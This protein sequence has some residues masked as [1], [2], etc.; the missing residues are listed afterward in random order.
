MKIFSFDLGSASI[1]ECVREDDKIQHLDSLL[2]DKDFASTSSQ[3][4]VRR[5]HRTRLAHKAREAWWEKCAAEAGIEVLRSSPQDQADKRLLREFPASGDETIYTSC[6]LRI[7]LLQGKKLEGWQIYKAVRSAFQH[8]G[9]DKDIAWDG[10]LRII[11]KKEKDGIEL[12]KKEKQRLEDRANEDKAAGEYANKLNEWF[13]DT[14]HHFPCYY[15]A[16]KLGLWTPEKPN[17]FKNS[18]SSH[19]APARNKDTDKKSMLV[20]PRSLV[21]KELQMLLKQASNFFPKLKDKENYI[22]FG[23]GE[24]PYAAITDEKYK[25]HRGKNWEH[26]GLLGQKTPRF[27]NRIV[28]QCYLIPRLNVCKAEDMLNKEV[29][30]LLALK[31][32]RFTYGQSTEAGLE[33]EQLNQIFTDYK[34]RLSGSFKEAVPA[35]SWKKEIKNYGGTVN[36][37]QKS[38]PMPKCSGRSRFCRPVLK[39][40][41]ELILS[42]KNPHDFYTEKTQN[43]ANTDPLK[44]LVKEDYS[45]LLKMPNNW[46]KIY[47]PDT[48][49]ED[50]NASAE[51]RKKR[52]T[53]I[54]NKINNPV[55]KHRLW[56]LTERFKVLAQKH[57]APDS[58]IFEVARDEFTSEEKLRKMEME[59][60]KNRKEIE[61]ALKNV[62]D[63]GLN[64]LKMRLLKQQGGIDI[65]DITENQTLCEADLSDYEVDHIVPRSRGGSDGISNK[66]LTKKRLNAD[67]LNRTP[68]EW[69]HQDETTWAKF[70]ENIKH[71]KKMPAAKKRLL[72]SEHADEMERKKNDLQAT[73]YIEKVA[74]QLA[75]LYF[76]WGLNTQDDERKIFVVTGGKT[77]T[78]RRQYGLDRLLHAGLEKDEFFK[79][80]KQGKIKE[81]N[82]ENKKHHALDALVLSIV[83]DYRYNP[84]TKKDEAPAFFTPTFCSAALDKVFPREIKTLKPAL[85]K[86]ISALRKRV[87]DGKERYFF[88][89]RLD[90]SIEKFFKM[91]EI[92]KPCKK[93]FDLQI[94]KDFMHML[95]Q[96]ITQE[97]WEK[98]LKSY[99]G[100][101]EQTQS[102][103]KIKKLS[104]ITNHCPAE[105]F[106]PEEVFN[107]DKSLKPKVRE[108]GQIGKMKG[109]WFT[110]KEKTHGM[111]LYKVK[112][113]KAEKWVTET[114]QPFESVY[115]KMKEY[116][117]KYGNVQHWFS[118][119]L[120]NLQNDV[121]GS[122]I[123]K[124]DKKPK[125]FKADLKKGLYKLNTISGTNVILTSLST[126]EKYMASLSNLLDNG[127]AKPVKE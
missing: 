54:L 114:I 11:E 117:A 6:L 12:T 78:I 80:V 73:A 113:K 13:A 104:M 101:N 52:I 55:V 103:E 109:Q 92:K 33:P 90:H 83:C 86:S 116:S 58:I 8:R 39:I 14:T 51:E 60:N 29:S 62:E 91:S 15:E 71:A 41:K 115:K 48:R 36:E 20:V 17:E 76:G 96:N 97:D 23:P 77:A 81:K 64:V 42:G 5:G 67:K 127:G 93:I 107:E 111:I 126:G 106:G 4:A 43:L 31:N 98:F 38:V 9:Y 35:T 121:E 69:L 87:V 53:E 61:T 72:I 88:V 37:A 65:Y 50:K 10:E 110:R 40:L 49:D 82:R 19:P 47:I 27:D 3:V 112:T 70:L 25:Q 34:D 28:S 24:K 125:N 68:Y 56:L 59:R 89:N 94:K 108:H 7:A 21:V 2:L 105:G 16:Y 102:F 18:L 45:F 66:V 79:L 46:K 95:S 120:I 30:F 32:M 85:R 122:V 124:I 57:G 100:Y 123:K 118:G 74:Q 84:E 22:I 63:T 119:A 26:Q 1:G 44:G 75:A 99:C